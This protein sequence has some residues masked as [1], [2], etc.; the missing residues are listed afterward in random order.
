MRKVIKNGNTIIVLLDDGNIIHKDNC[1]DASYEAVKSAK[2]DTE[3]LGVLDDNFKEAAAK[4]AEVQSLF[5]DVEKSKYLIK[6]GDS[7][8]WEGV[9]ELSIPE[10][11]V[12]AIIKAEQEDNK[13]ALEAY[14]NFWVLLSLNPDSRCRE[15]LFW[16]LEKWDMKIA[17]CGL[18]IGYRNV[19]IYSK[20]TGAIYTQSLC[21][22]VLSEYSKLKA[23]QKLIS[24]YW[25]V[26]DE[27]IYQVVKSD[28]LEYNQY[29][30]DE[31]VMFNLK[32]L[33]EELK[34]VNFIA[35]NVGDDTI[36]TDHHSHTFRIKVGE[37]VSMPREETD[38]CQEN[39]CSRGLHIGSLGWLK[40]GY[41]GQQGLVCLI[42]PAKVVAVPRIDD[43]GKLRT[44]EYLPIA[45]IEYDENHDVIPYNVED[46]FDS[47]W[48][49]EIL[50]D[51]ELSTEDTPVYR[52]GIPIIPELN[53][54]TVTDNLF[55][56]AKKYVLE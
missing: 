7:I 8:Y 43:Y 5:E 37:I 55:E 9:S 21:D 41:Y 39:S 45:L 24:Q 33:Y 46:G 12:K 36:Y 27:N 22:F 38:T 6:R 3:V 18:F 42:N 51:G 50:Y 4:M 30:C 23:A 20:G 48:I 28:S 16:F 56:I 26:V 52:L 2:S 53:S 31:A 13:D 1:D 35:K 44:C 17:K 15:N 11:L 14:H 54:T 19:D 47:K 49:K 29:V 10:T 25:I 34:A 32:S 40:K